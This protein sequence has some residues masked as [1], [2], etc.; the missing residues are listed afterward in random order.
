MTITTT[1]L[2]EEGREF[3]SLSIVGEDSPIERLSIREFKFLSAAFDSPYKDNHGKILSMLSHFFDQSTNDVSAAIQND[4]L[5]IIKEDETT[6]ALNRT[7]TGFLSV[8]SATLE[9]LKV[10]MIAPSINTG[11]IV[12]LRLTESTE[13]DLPDKMKGKFSRSADSIRTGR[14]IEGYDTYFIVDGRLRLGREL[15]SVACAVCISAHQIPRIKH[16]YLGDRPSHI[17]FRAGV[18]KYGVRDHDDIHVWQQSIEAA[19]KREATAKN[20]PLQGGL[21]NPR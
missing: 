4:P 9:Q 15:A 20:N 6:P 17:D 16:P 7:F 8:D 11:D 21:V 13:E 1:E 14:H 10:K 18:E 5:A 19:K 12:A 2:S 3:R